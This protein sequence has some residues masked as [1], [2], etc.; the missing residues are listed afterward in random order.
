MIEIDSIYEVV[1]AVCVAFTLVVYPTLL[2]LGHLAN[3]RAEKRKEQ[4][5]N[6]E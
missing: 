1:T 4:E 5:V 2:L 6:S 3:K